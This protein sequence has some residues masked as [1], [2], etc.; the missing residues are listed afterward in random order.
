MGGRF[1]LNTSCRREGM[2]LEDIDGV[3]MCGLLG[4][5]HINVYVYV[6]RVE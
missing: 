6:C 5:Y 1:T 3:K 2:F 4:V